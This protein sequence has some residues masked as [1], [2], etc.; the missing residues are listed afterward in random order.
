MAQ[1]SLAL[2]LHR[3]TEAQKHRREQE[4]RGESTEEKTH[5]TALLIFSCQVASQVTL[6]SWTTL[7][8]S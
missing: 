4:G 6:S 8:H 5:L 1:K 2:A 7:F 3:R